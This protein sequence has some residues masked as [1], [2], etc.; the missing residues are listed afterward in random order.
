MST[1]DLNELFIPTKLENTSLDSTIGMPTPA[2]DTHD[3]FYLDYKQDETDSPFCTDYAVMCGAYINRGSKNTETWYRAADTNNYKQVLTCDEYG[4][5]GSSHPYFT[6]HVIRPAMRVDVKTFL[7]FRDFAAKT[8]NNFDAAIFQSRKH[9]QLAFGL[10]FPSCHVNQQTAEDLDRLFKA[11][12][13]Q[14]TGAT[15]L[16][17]ADETP[18]IEYEYH[19]QRFVR[20]AVENNWDIS[21]FTDGTPCP[22]TGEYAW[23]LV[24]P[25]Y[26]NITNWEDLP[27]SINPDGTGKADYIEVIADKGILA[28]PFMLHQQPITPPNDILWQ[29]SVIRAYLNGYDLYQEIDRG[30]G[31]KQYTS[32]YN[33]DFTGRGFLYEASQ[34]LRSQYKEIVIGDGT[35]K[36]TTVQIKDTQ[37]AEHPNPYGF[38]YDELSNDDLL[39]LYIQS[40]TPVFLHGPSGVGK[41]SRVKQIDPNP[42][43]ITLR[44]QMNPEE[45]DGTL[46][47]ETGKYIPP[48]WY[49][50]LCEKCEKD[51]EHIHTLFIDELTN[52]KPTVQSLVYSII[53]DRAG[54]DGLWPL[55]DNSV[56]VAA[57]NENVDNLAAYP[58]TNALFRRLSHI[59]YQVD[60]EA[61]LDWAMGVNKLSRL[62]PV[63][64]DKAKH[65]RI[66]PAI[67]AFI[68]SQKDN[69]LNQD[70][71][72]EDP[73]IV[74]DPR[75]WE[76]A[77]NVLYSTKNP[78]ALQPAVGEEITASFVDFV[79]SIQITVEDVVKG[80]YDPKTLTMMDFA[81]KHATAVGLCTASEKDLPVVRQF[82]Q[83]YL[84]QE[85]RALFDSLW[86][87]NDPERAAV[88]GELDAVITQNAV[89]ENTAT[90]ER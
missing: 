76:I 53:L 51:P 72:E 84:G 67:V 62:M 75:K 40:K 9:H 42:T 58:L 69:I 73:K 44:P 34:Y 79:Q 17:A 68:A 4:F 61:W 77:S 16:G 37:P 66:H 22:R 78:N 81:K 25:I 88:I 32:N 64:P 50:Q 27:Q 57:G 41:S 29:N 43:H 21:R 26:F 19:N 63:A 2:F 65:A 11:K 80:N 86:I 71:D 31:N 15:Y 14:K 7:E 49:T 36:P 45:V 8:A 54:K 5:L 28:M 52:V 82:I 35:T 90:L 3:R 20:I 39:K 87:R 56:V 38:T 1:I 24:T 85:V 48:L 89:Q 13:L 30:N 60:K 59:Y 70:L 12:Q 46:D 6:A 33:Y 74:T 55:P 23:A 47:R 18:N 10:R 83:Q